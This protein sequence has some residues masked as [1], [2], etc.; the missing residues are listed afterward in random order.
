MAPSRDSDFQTRLSYSAR[1]LG[2]LLAGGVSIGFVVG[3]AIMPLSLIRYFQENHLESRL[4]HILLACTLGGG[5][6]SALAG[7]LYLLTHFSTPNVAARLYHA[8]RRLAPLYLAGFFALLFRCEVWKGRDL[9]FL[10]LVVLFGL[11]TWAAVTSALQAGPFPWEEKI[12]SPLRRFHE[13]LVQA[14]PRSSHSLP[15]ILVLVGVIFYVSYFG[16]YTYCFYYSLR[17]GYDTGIYDSLL[18]NM[19]HGGS[20]FKTP[21]WAGPGRSHFGNHAE[22]F[23][24]VLLPFYAI[25]QNSGT[26][27]L[28]QSAVLGAAAIPLYK[29]VRRHIDRWPACILVLTYLLYPALHGENLFEFHFLPLGPFLLWWAWYFLEARR[30]RWAALFV[31]LTLSC[32]ED[33]SSWVAVLGLYFLLTGRRPRAGVLLAAIGALYCFALKFIAMPY[34]G[35]GESFTTIYKDLVPQGGKGFGSVVMT[36]LANPAFTM[37]TLAEMD[38]LLYMLQILVPLAF[39]PFRRPIWLV[40]AIPGFFFTVLSTHYGP[41][42][43]INFQYSAHWIA[44]FFPG[45]A[46]GLEWMER[47]SAASGQPGLAALRRRAALAT[48]I[49]MALPLSYQFGAIFQRTNS[50]GGPIKYTFGIDAEGKRRHQAA[51]RLV[52]HLPRRAKVSGSGFT[53]PFVSN[54]PDAYNMTISNETDADYLVFPSE[55]GDLIGSERETLTRVLRNGDFGV[56]AV[57]PP[58]AL[59]KRGHPIGGNAALMARW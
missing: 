14:M 42:V 56:V 34:V 11:A 58:F 27:M 39:L 37:S 35:G 43:S 23:A 4:R 50:W 36:M 53:T 29:L 26:L 8:A 45:V 49:C 33:V 57:E 51:E 30:D 44:F 7:A 19:L 48:M 3:V 9:A 31:L 38:K 52:R 32:R 24:Y 16:Y 20:F 1:A 25:R 13:G 22:F 46:L 47:R 2:L 6:A 54:R 55:A 21:P 15:F 5:V 41:L 12:R 40:L 17:S 59:A 18:W 10:T 28:I